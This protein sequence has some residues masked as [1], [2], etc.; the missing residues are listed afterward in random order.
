MVL[1]T[2]SSKTTVQM[3]ERIIATSEVNAQEKQFVLQ[4]PALGGGR[5][6]VNVLKEKFK[7]ARGTEI[8][9]DYTADQ[10]R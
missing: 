2:V 4:P 6:A 5:F 3:D 7:P 10:I 9:I 8:F 1:F